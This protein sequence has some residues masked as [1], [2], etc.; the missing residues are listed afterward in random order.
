MPSKII[1][2]SMRWMRERDWLAET[3]EKRADV[4]LSKQ[5]RDGIRTQPSLEPGGWRGVAFTVAGS[6]EESWVW[7]K[8]VSAILE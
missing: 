7:R 1:L 2:K 6:Q 4:K 3:R 5:G 8:T